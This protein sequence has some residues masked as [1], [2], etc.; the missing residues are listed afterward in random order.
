MMNTPQN[1]KGKQPRIEILDQAEGETQVR[2][3]RPIAFGAPLRRQPADQA[4]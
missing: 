1:D 4:C 3:L 2:A